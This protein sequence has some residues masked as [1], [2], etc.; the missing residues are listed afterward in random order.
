MPQISSYLDE[1]TL[2]LV[3]QAAKA[4]GVS[5]SRWVAN[6]TR[7]HA[8]QPGDLVFGSFASKIHA[9]GTLR[10]GCVEPLESQGCC[11]PLTTG[12]MPASKA[13]K[14]GPAEMASF[15]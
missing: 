13:S 4:N 9:F 1:A 11:N 5:K 8:A 6:I 15:K 2:A 3:E 10:I 7:K 14:R 12:A